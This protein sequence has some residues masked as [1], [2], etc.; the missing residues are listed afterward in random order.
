MEFDIRNHTIFLMLHGSNAYGMATPES[1]IDLKGIIIPPKEYFLGFAKQ[2]E[3]YQSTYPLVVDELKLLETLTNRQVLSDE[4]MD[5]SIY[6]IRKLFTLCAKNNPNIIEI[7]FA[8]DKFT[9][10]KHPVMNKLMENRDLFLS[11]RA[12]F[13]FRGY[14]FSQLKKI[15]R[16]RRWLLSPVE[17]RPQ[18]K[19]FN[20]PLRTVIPTNQLL[21]AESLIKKKVDDWL[22]QEEMSPE[23][24]LEVRAT[25]INTFVELFSGL[26]MSSIT[27]KYDE[28]DENVLANSAGRL[29]G[30][31]DNFLELLDRER[32]YKSSLKEYRSYQAWKKNRN[33]IRAKTEAVCGYDTKNAAHLV[34]LMKMAKEIIEF[35]KVNVYRDDAEELL[36]IRNGH[37]SYEE[38][39]E[40]AGKQDKIIQDIY[41]SGKSPLPKKPNVNKLNNLCVEIVEEFNV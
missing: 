23:L 27:D 21:A 28:F 36:E 30:Y 15:N 17:I 34:R 33:P 35:G 2:F 3:Q 41:D 14:A 31:D 26:K 7:L 1:D 20:L 13:S 16:H 18:R 39:V 25:T 10:H 4:K 22:F 24:L 5:C 6:D 32:K 38:I 40:W 19:D 11:T 8:D 37:K 9:L 12:N 29:L